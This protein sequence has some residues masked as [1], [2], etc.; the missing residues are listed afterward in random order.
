MGRKCITALWWWQG[1]LVALEYQR[2]TQLGG[3]LEADRRREWQRLP[4]V[5]DECGPLLL[6]TNGNFVYLDYY[7][8]S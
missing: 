6:F 7:T 4:P 1:E 2:V 8:I 5:G 3:P